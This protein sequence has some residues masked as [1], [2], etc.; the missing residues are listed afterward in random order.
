MK[1]KFFDNN[2]LKESKN[3]VWLYIYINTFKN[4][5]DKFKIIV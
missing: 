5:N 1:Y 3:S 2:I 4:T